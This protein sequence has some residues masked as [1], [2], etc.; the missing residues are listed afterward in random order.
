MN[1]QTPISTY[2]YLNFSHSSTLVYS[3]FNIKSLRLW[4]VIQY[5]RVIKGYSFLEL[6][7][8]DLCLN[9]TPAYPHCFDLTM[10]LCSDEHIPLEH[11]RSLVQDQE[12]TQTQQYTPIAAP[13]T[14]KIGASHQEGNLV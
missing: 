14:R 12:K 5:I 9:K 4:S 1:L 13:K 11:K 2:T 6:T 8:C 7:E 10:F 3:G